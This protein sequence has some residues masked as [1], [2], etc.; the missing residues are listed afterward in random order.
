MP[1][2][3]AYGG[4]NSHSWDGRERLVT[5]V[6]S[7]SRTNHDNAMVLRTCAAGPVNRPG[8]APITPAATYVPL[9]FKVRLH[10][11]NE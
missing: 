6:T 3:L 9:G 1:V 10:A 8:D 11:D 2:W 5:K 7:L 4:R